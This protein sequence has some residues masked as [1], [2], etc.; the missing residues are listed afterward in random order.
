M[1]ATE[2]LKADPTTVCVSVVIPTRNRPELVVMAIASALRQ[3][4]GNLEVIV[5]VDGED[6]LTRE[7]LSAFSDARLRVIDLAVNVGGAE[8]R[9]IGIRAARGEW[10]AFLDDDDEWLPQK[11]SRQMQAARQMPAVWP[12][13][14]SQMIVRTPECELIRPLR[15]YEPEKPISEFLFCRKSLKD[16]PFAMQTSTLMA[17][18]GLMLAIPFRSGLQR[19]QDWDWLLRAG[20]NSGVE[21]AVIDE[22]LVIYRTEDG[23]E[24]LSRS[25]DWEFSMAWGSEMRGFFSAKAYSWFIAAECASRAVKSRAGFRIYAEI[26]RRFVFDGRPSLGS[27]AMMVAFL[28]LPRG[29]RKGVH[30]VARRWRRSGRLLPPPP[31]NDVQSTFGME[32]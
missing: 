15:S 12:V 10:V 18:R 17:R 6:P 24:S 1:E 3:S 11:L 5:V 27:A 9:N 4:F 16:G 28:G 13:I 32:H 22:P 8:A 26:A 31:R 25:H 30:R 23:R 14:S 21:F 2:I 7:A 19:H 20:R 29:W